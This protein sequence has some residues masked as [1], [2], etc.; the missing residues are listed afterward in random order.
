MSIKRL[1]FDLETSPNI[2]FTWRTGNK[3][4]VLPESIIQERAIICC[5]YKW[6][7]EKKINSITWNNGDDKNILKEFTEVVN[8]ADE[9]V[10]HNIDRFDLRWLN[11]RSLYHD[12]PVVPQ[13]KTVDTLKI[14]RRH[15]LFNSNRLDYLGKLL[16]GEGKIKTDFDLWKQIVLGNNESSLLQMV[17]YCKKDVDLLQ[18]VW[19]KLRSYELSATHVG[20]LEGKDRWTCAYCG[21]EEVHLSKTRATPKGIKQRQMVCGTCGRYYTIADN[22]YARYCVVKRKGE[23]ENV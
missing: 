6:E 15:F 14:A 5:C 19:D 2:C 18:R 20:S 22:V 17:K 16:L 23:Q 4:R 1:F 3:V 11:T 12:L 7:N 10:G 8:N 9:V 21:S 13:C